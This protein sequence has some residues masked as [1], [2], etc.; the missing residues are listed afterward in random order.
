MPVTKSAALLQWSDLLEAPKPAL[1]V[2]ATHPTLAAE[3]DALAAGF[4]KLSHTDSADA[5]NLLPLL[6]ARPDVTPALHVRLQRAAALG[7][8]YA[9]ICV[10]SRHSTVCL[11]TSTTAK[12]KNG[13]FARPC[14]AATS[15][16]P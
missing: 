4:E 13:A 6:L 7:A 14:G 5:L 3:P 1:T 15:T 8:A 16:R 2:L 12:W 10:P 11:Q 9:V